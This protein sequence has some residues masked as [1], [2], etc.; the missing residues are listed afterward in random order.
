M[1]KQEYLQLKNWL[2]T[3]IVFA[4]MTMLGGEI[5]IGWTVYPEADNV[6]LSM[7][8][9]CGNLTM[10]QLACGV[11]FGGIG[12]PLQ[13]YGYKAIGRIVE[14]GGNKKYGWFICLGAK[15]IAFWGGIV[16]IICVA[17][18]FLCR[19]E[20][21]HT[22]NRLP[23]NVVDFTL[24]LVLPISAVFM[25]L[26]LPMTIAML[27]P[28]I[29]GKTLFPKWAVIFNPIMYKIL[30]NLLAYVAPNT[31][32]MNGIRMSNMGIGSLITFTGLLV[33]FTKKAQRP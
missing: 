21:T 29:K 24:W 27:L 25:I 16:H 31:E 17:L 2:I 30:L 19:L 23:Q 22:L 7:I 4:A 10:L 28:V 15:A 18:M 13:Y 1:T 9:G 8:M 11:L 12:I 33:L 20:Q 3:G 6:L 5:P 26:Y 32:L 14:M